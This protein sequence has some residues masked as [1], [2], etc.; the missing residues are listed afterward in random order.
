MC[1]IIAGFHTGKGATPVNQWAIDQYE[2]QHSRGSQ[3]FGII[4]FKEG[5]AIKVLR[6]TEPAKFMF[7]LHSQNF[8]M[9][10][11]HHRMPTST[12]NKI[13]QTHPILVDNGSLAHAYLIIHNGVIRNANELFSQ[14]VNELGFSYQTAEETLKPNIYRFN[15]S[16]ALAIEVARFIEKQTEKI[17]AK[18]SAAFIALQIDRKTQKPLKVFFGRNDSNPLKM[19][20]SRGKMHLSSEGEGELIQPFFLYSCPLKGEM[21][22]TKTALE[23]IEDPKP[24]YSW[25]NKTTLPATTVGTSSQATL[26]STL[27]KTV[28]PLNSPPAGT[29]TEAERWEEWKNS[30]GGF[31]D[32]FLDVDV[33]DADLGEIVQTAVDDIDVIVQEYLEEL[34]DIDSAALSSPDE[35]MKQIRQVF[36]NTKRSIINLW[37]ERAR[38][39]NAKSVIATP[40]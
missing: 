38:Q 37:N 40:V 13:K 15:D 4:G 5:G 21:P 30:G 20:K 6:S 19:G 23:F 17:G 32:E 22:L 2:D 24:A 31:D 18:G 14:H 35:S 34:S 39:A 16:E 12:A 25:E 9:M 1:G 8:P 11:V 27:P 33:P 29:A 36:E 10:M 7:D 26:P 28:I 3:G